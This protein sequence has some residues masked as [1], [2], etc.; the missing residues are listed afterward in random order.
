[1][2]AAVCRAFGE[3][4]SVEH[5]ELTQPGPGD[6]VVAVKAVAICHSDI[7]FAEGGWGGSLP[8]VYGHEAAGI[9]TW[10]G[11][12]VAHLDEGDE[13]VV[14]MV[15]GCGT[16]HCCSRGNPGSCE[17]P[18]DASAPA[19]LLDAAG[20]P[21]IQGLQTGAFAEHV[22]VDARQVVRTPTGFGHERASLLA[23]GVITGF[24]AVANTAQVEA[25]ASVAV[26]GAGG[27][28]LNAIQAARILR[29]DPIVAVDLA[30]SKLDAARNFGAT[31]AVDGRAEDAV[32]A[33]KSAT[34]GRGV[35]Y[36]FVTVGAGAAMAQSYEMLA[37]GGAAVLVGI[38]ADGVTS[39]FDPVRLASLSQ[40]IL[41]SKMGAG[42][43]HR[44]IPTLID[45][46]R[47]GRLMLDELITERFA[48]RDINHAVAGA[49]TGAALRNMIVM[50]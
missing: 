43:V 32:A 30:R 13:V 40:R 12:K 9:V 46:H 23:C 1:M 18:P 38:P 39:T 10:A 20:K 41:G 24:G 42:D 4:F 17:A 28:G 44:D 36:A 34:G 50:A 27:V 37:P 25:G 11:D 31:H 5:L 21:V 49:K 35:D 48:L 7:I 33:V 26:I 16:C 6:V 3:P 45:H 47:A 29:A 8:A 19:R 2:E 22:A 14:T 15:R